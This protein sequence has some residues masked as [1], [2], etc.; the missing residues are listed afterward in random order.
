MK[1]IIEVELAI[2]YILDDVNQG[3]ILEDL[4]DIISQTDTKYLEKD[5][6]VL[7]GTMANYKITVETE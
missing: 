2:P 7:C 6:V 3:D 4:G 1:I 5:N